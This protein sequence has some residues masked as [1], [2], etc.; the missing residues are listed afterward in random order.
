V[1]HSVTDGYFETM[2]IRLLSGRMFGRDDRFSE[3]Q[4]VGSAPRE[5]GVAV[6][7]AS[8][9]RMLWPGRPAVGQALWL[10]TI[11]TV[12]WREVVGVVEDMHFYSIGETP[13]AHVFVPWTQYPTG[14]PLLV[15]RLGAPGAS[16]PAV[17]EVIQAVHPGTYVEQV[18]SLDSLVSRATAQPRFT[19]QLVAS[20]ALLALVLA[21]V[22]IYGTLSYVVGSRTR[23]IGIRL[24]L[25]ASRWEILTDTIRHGVLPAV[26]GGVAGLAI[27]VA[28]VR[29]FRALLFGIEPVD[30]GSFA[31][32]AA[33][34]LLIAFGAALGPAL[35]ASRV[36]PAAALRAE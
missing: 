10:P 29:T 15:V 16:I 18:A 14:G 3:A 1:S 12:P 30:P 17:R 36:D 35:R 11:D 22:G 8:A 13:I 4:H 5:R 26:A 20:F 25:G 24:A 6:V 33:A 23:E 31:G 34:L 21:A 7:S 2:G 32:G 19:T 27:A 9:A 28:L